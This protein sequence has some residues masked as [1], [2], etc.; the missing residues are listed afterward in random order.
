MFRLVRRFFIS[1]RYLNS[2]KAK[3][4]P[5]KAKLLFII[6]TLFLCSCGS[7]KKAQKQSEMV[8]IGSITKSNDSVSV[9]KDFLIT[10]TDSSTEDFE[11]TIT[12]YDTSRPIDT[13]TGKL[14]VK[15]SVKVNKRKG[16]RKD[17]RKEKS[18]RQ[19]AKVEN[20]ISTQAQDSIS[21]ETN[22]EKRETTVPKQIGNVMK[23]V[24]VFVGLM[25]VWHIV[26]SHGRR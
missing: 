5:M 24:C 15:V 8:S 3:V 10:Q 13:I 16:V 7:S 4:Y 9:V 18:D 6:I 12:E 14:P 26:R 2:D 21:V 23:W 25:I 1:G 22:K 11:M 19:T 17:S 20:L